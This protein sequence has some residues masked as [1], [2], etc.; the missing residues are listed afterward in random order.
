MSDGPT[1]AELI[2]DA[3]RRKEAEIA[4]HEGFL[5]N[6]HLQ[7]D[8]H[9]YYADELSLATIT[10]TLAV[11]QMLADT[12]QIPTPPPVAGAWMTADIDPET[13]HRVVEP[14][15]CGQFK[16][17]ARALYDRNGLIWGAEMVHKATIEAM[18]AT[19]ATAAE[20]LAYDHLQGWPE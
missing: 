11:V 4:R 19:G 2:A 14:M 15:T 1:H 9:L 16:Q 17:L 10:A 12:D 20:I 3:V 13:G 5:R 6:Q 18:A 7:H 8:G